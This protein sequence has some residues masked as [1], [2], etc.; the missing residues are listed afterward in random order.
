MIAAN[1]GHRLCQMASD[2]RP[3]HGSGDPDAKRYAQQVTGGGQP[4]DGCGRWFVG[5]WH[6]RDSWRHVTWS[7]AERTSE[8]IG[9]KGGSDRWATCVRERGHGPLMVGPWPGAGLQV[10]GNSWLTCGPKEEKI[11]DFSFTHFSMME[12][13]FFGRG[14]S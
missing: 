6:Q 12:K 10:S 4:L 11:S 2:R 5:V 7:D 3:G 1:W 8:A 14:N 9:G 13:R